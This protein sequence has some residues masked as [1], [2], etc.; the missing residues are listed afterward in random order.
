MELGE[1]QEDVVDLCRQL[2]GRRYDDALDMVSLGWFV[3]LEKSLSNNQSVCA[4]YVRETEVLTST[5]GTRKARVFPL[6]VTASTTTS[7]LPLKISRQDFCTGVGCAKP[8]DDM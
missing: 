1:S 6:P 8:I 4:S 5:T 7:L 3:A 2:T